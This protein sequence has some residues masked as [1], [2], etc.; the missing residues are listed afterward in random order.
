MISMEMMRKLPKKSHNHG[1]TYPMVEVTRDAH[2]GFR[3]C[4]V[5]DSNGKF[6]REIIINE[7]PKRDE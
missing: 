5:Y 7:N 2:I 6:I 3:Y 4:D 1:A